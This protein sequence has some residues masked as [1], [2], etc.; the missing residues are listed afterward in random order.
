MNSI[1]LIAKAAHLAPRWN[2][3]T[4]LNEF[5]EL[6]ESQPK[7][8]EEFL[9]C[10]GGRDILINLY[11]FASETA[12]TRSWSLLPHSASVMEAQM[13]VGE[14]TITLSSGYQRHPIKLNIQAGK[15]NLVLISA[16][17]SGITSRA[18]SL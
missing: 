16:Q 15:L 1:N 4:I 3:A 13:P 2:K 8:I 17:N 9:N 14:R 11:N 12:D 6:I 18:F 7:F 5:H 10:G